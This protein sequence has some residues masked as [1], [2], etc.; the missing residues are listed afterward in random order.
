MFI[1]CYIGELLS[2]QVERSFY[3]INAYSIHYKLKFLENNDLLYLLI[4]CKG[5]INIQ[6]SKLALSSGKGYEMFNTCHNYVQLSI[7]NRSRKINGYVS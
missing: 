6:Y 3:S 5:W 1:F 7:E 2:E 4:G